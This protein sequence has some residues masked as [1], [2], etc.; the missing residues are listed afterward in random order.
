TG[1]RSI[2]V[3]VD[4]EYPLEIG[5]MEQLLDHKL[6]IEKDL[7]GDTITTAVQLIKRI[8]GYLKEAN[9]FNL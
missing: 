6:Q 1:L 5:V 8:K 9:K 7:V 2:A 3:L 4:R